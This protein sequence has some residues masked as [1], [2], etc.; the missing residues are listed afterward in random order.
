MIF[1]AD[2]LSGANESSSQGL[3]VSYFGFS[4]P[5]NSL[6]LRHENRNYRTVSLQRIWFAV[7]WMDRSRRVPAGIMR[8]TVGLLVCAGATTGANAQNVE[9]STALIGS[10]AIAVNSR[11]GKVYAID[12]RRGS[13]SV[14]DPRAKSTASVRVGAE[15][16]AIAVNEATG[17]IYVANNQG[18]SLS[19]IDGPSDSVLATLQVGSL[20]YVVAANRPRT[21]FMCQTRSAT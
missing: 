13:V 18:G 21:R 14:F 12:S 8:V 17:R 19:V 9:P 4:P 16:V 10:R 15:P 3:I 20:P 2:G 11:T 7:N 6:A 5:R 1:G